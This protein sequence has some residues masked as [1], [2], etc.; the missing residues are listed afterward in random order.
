MFDGFGPTSG[1][2]TAW[3]RQQH[4]GINEDQAR[5]MKRADKIFATW[6]IN[7]RFAA[8]AA[9]NHC[10]HRG[11]QL[12]QCHAAHNR[13]RHK[14]RQITD[15]AAAQCQNRIVALYAVFQQPRVHCFSGSQ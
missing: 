8:D 2:F 10:Q 15:H 13:R 14:A 9:V 7:A 11:W 6:M 4:V 3:Q 1:A 12:H 5:L